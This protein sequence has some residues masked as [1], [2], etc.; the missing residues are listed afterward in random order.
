MI[1]PYNFLRLPLVEKLTLRRRKIDDNDKF[2][3]TYGLIRVIKV[4][5][6]VSKK[7][8]MRLSKEHQHVSIAK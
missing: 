6:K 8:D 4:V 2:Q 7:V 5:R 3:K 1:L